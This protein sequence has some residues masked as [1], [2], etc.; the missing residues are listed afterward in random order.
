MKTAPGRPINGKDVPAFCYIIADFTQE[1]ETA[2]RTCSFIQAD[3]GLSYFGY[4]PYWQAYFTVMNY[5]SFL[6]GARQRNRVFFDKL[7]LN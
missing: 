7:H 3:D 5:D 6:E 4:L 2:C 1:L